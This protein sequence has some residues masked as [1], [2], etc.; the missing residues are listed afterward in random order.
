[1]RLPA[2]LSTHD[3]PSAELQAA[4]LDGELFAID[5]CFSPI[6][7]IEQRRHRAASLAAI[8]PD[9][10]IAEQHSAAWVH[11]AL[12]HAPARHEFCADTRARVRPAGARFALREVVID[13]S[14]LM[15]LGGMSVTTPL[16]TVLDLARF[17]SEFGEAERQVTRALMVCGRFGF[18]DC[19]SALDRRRNLPG[20]RQ[21]IARLAEFQLPKFQLPEFQLPEFQLPA[22]SRP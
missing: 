3:L 22:V 6:D 11:G 7:E 4:R 17:S 5:E 13:D 10:L 9:R 1:M 21:A 2:V 8:V 12:L 15:E 18:I 14:D 19:V 20:K 16:R